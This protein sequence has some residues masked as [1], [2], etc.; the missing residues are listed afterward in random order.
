MTEPKATPGKF[1]SID[2]GK[3]WEGYEQDGRAGDRLTKAGDLPQNRNNHLLPFW[4][5]SSYDG[6]PHTFH[7]AAVA[8]YD[9]DT[10]A[11][12]A[13]IRAHIADLQRQVTAERERLDALYAYQAGP[14]PVTEEEAKS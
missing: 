1:V 11:Q 2:T 14:M 9:A 8:R 13:P 4:W 6:R 12:A 5:R 10:E 7:V 3:A